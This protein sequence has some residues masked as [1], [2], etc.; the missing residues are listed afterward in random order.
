MK[1]FYV[2]ALLLNLSIPKGS[3]WVKRLH[4]KNKG[5]KIGVKMPKKIPIFG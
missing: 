4:L 5:V 3:I 1:H 2:K